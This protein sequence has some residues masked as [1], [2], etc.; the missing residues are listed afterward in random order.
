MDKK[1]KCTLAIS[2]DGYIA[3]EQGGYDWIVGDGSHEN[4]TEKKWDFEAYMSDVDVV[5]MGR[6]CYD[7]QMHK[8]FA[9]KEVIVMTSRK[10][11]DNSVT[12]LSENIRSHLIDIRKTK[13]IFVFGGGNVVSQLK[14]IIDEYAIGIIPII[15]G[16]GIPLFHPDE[17]RVKLNLKEI[18]CEDG[19][20]VLT[21][22]KKEA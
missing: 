21:Y 5:V 8:E 10:T 7:L 9:N 1:I 16:K 14:D 22:T 12:F 4:N 19:I 6:N 3:D 11:D 20:V 15:L 18:M 2:L 13:N 17:N